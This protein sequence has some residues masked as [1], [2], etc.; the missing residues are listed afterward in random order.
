[1]SAV[2]EF[3]FVNC[4]FLGK[5]SGVAEEFFQNRYRLAA[6]IG[7]QLIQ[8]GVKAVIAAGWAVDDSA[9]LDFTQNFYENMFAGNNF[10]DSILK[11]R[12][13]I[14]QKYGNSNNTWGAYQCYGDPFYKFDPETKN[15]KTT[16]NFII[17]EEAE[18]ELNNL[19]NEMETFRYSP[20]EYLDRL[21]AIYTAIELAGI[22]TSKITEKEALIYADLGEYNYA[23]LKFESL[24]KNE[25]ADFSVST[26][27]KYCNIK[28][29]KYVAD[30]KNKKEKSATLIPKIDV[31]IRD[32][33]NL[34][35]IGNGAERNS[36]IASAYKRKAMICTTKTQKDKTY[37]QAAKF[38]L[39]AHN[40]QTNIY[41][42]YCLTNW[43]ELE[44]AS[45]FSGAHTWHEDISFSN[46]NYRIRTQADAVNL[47]N[48]LKN[49]MI[50]ENNNSDFWH[51]M[52]IANVKLCLLVLTSSSNANHWDETLESIKKVWKKAGSKGKRLAEI[53][54][55]DFLIDT[56]SI[57]NK[58][59]VMA[60]KK[61]IE[62]LK[63]ELEKM[64]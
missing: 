44:A 37:R 53:E 10:G 18:T 20:K 29:K 64:L 54:H 1:M 25:R 24:L 9:A 50:A 3:V 56:I 39:E 58:P 26:L 55:L 61:R 46:T 12:Q 2:P 51:M 13:Y 59:A 28:A 49:A 43:F 21:Q 48:V 63:N 36:L 57:S 30:F 23:I 11:A 33:E 27:E 5:T 22:R 45:V 8:N 17:A 4:C 7:T 16:F 34:L 52:A 15:K 14:Y 32:L 60:L 42:A 62:Q 40:K 41:S 47:L 38:Y 31:V 19:H 35:L 6:N